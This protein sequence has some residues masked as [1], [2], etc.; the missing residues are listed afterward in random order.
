MTV[1]A[2]IAELRQSVL[3]CLDHCESQ[4]GSEID[5][6]ADHYWQIDPGD[7]FDPYTEPTAVMGQITDDLA[8][9]RAAS[10][11]E[12]ALAWHELG[13]LLGPLARLAVL[14]RA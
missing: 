7:A 10:D 2:S 4:L 3:R 13:H 1:Q 14:M 12:P 11:D 5:L 8:E 6:D 9:I